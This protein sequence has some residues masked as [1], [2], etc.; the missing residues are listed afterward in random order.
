VMDHA[1]EGRSLPA[2]DPTT[3]EDS[4]RI[5]VQGDPPIH[6][7]V[8]LRDFVLATREVTTPETEMTFV[9]AIDRIRAL[10]SGLTLRLVDGE[11]GLPATTGGASLSTDQLTEGDVHPDEQGV[12]RFQNR[13]PGRYEVRTFLKGYSFGVSHVDLPPGITTDLGTIAFVKG[14][15]VSGR[16]VDESGSPRRVPMLITPLNGS[17]SPAEDPSTTNFIV[18]TDPD[19][20]FSVRNLQRSRYC[21]RVMSEPAGL[22][23]E[24]ETGW[25]ARPVLVDTS[26]GSVHGIVVI[27][28]RPKQ[29]TLH[30]SAGGVVGTNY[31]ILTA[32][33]LVATSGE[34]EQNSSMSIDLPRGDYTI[35]LARGQK[36]IRD[37]PLQVAGQTTSVEIDP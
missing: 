28:E 5:Y 12:V 35:R 32:D 22:Q 31:A 19:G 16:C 24:G 25:S 9:I 34:F 13:L 21:L 17:E 6:V 11:T 18:K 1:R 3:G 4:D 30:P 14:I 27:V 10:L 23:Q 36:K 15:V 7:N 29:V 33:G 8:L 37:L 26:D 2:E 20:S